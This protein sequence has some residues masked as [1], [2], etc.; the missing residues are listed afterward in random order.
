MIVGY[1]DDTKNAKLL[2]RFFTFLIVLI[3]RV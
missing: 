1:Y 2:I 3:R